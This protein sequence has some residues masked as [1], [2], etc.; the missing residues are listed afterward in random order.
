MKEA[1]DILLV[2]DNPADVGLTR[3][4][5]AGSTHHAS[6]H[7]VP[8]GEQ[9]IAFLRRLGKYTQASRPDL[10]VLDLN[11]PRK[12]GQ[13]VLAEVKTDPQLRTIPIVVFTT[14]HAE[15]DIIHSYEL[16]ANCYI[17]KPGNLGDFF[18]AVQSI[19]EYWFGFTSL[20]H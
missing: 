11:M 20:P 16:G 3:E 8:D 12:G 9:A 1:P 4:V 6:I 15:K 13:A 5:L 17:S 14:S 18:S 19:E 2:D 10:V 7:N